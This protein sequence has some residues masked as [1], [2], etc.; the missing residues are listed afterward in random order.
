VTIAASQAGYPRNPAWY[1]NL[2]ANPDVR[3]GGQRF[4]ARLVSDE[5][6]RARLWELADNIFPAFASYRLSAIR[7]GRQIPIV[8]LTAS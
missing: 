5:A 7:Y 8:Q 4:S 3:L 2:V 6:E 1:Y